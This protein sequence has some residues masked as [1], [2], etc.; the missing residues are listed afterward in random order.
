MDRLADLLHEPLGLDLIV[1]IVSSA[2]AFL[3]S[4]VSYMQ[5]L[6]ADKQQG[7][8][9][10]SLYLG[11]FFYAPGSLQMIIQQ[12]WGSILSVSLPSRVPKETSIDPITSV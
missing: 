12:S 10:G 5:P 11:P 6:Q 3:S 9:K 2:H 8:L 7:L 1:Q 4:S